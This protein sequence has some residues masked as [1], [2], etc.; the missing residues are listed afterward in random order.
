[1]AQL[2]KVFC[3]GACDGLA[4]R[5]AHLWVRRATNGLRCPLCGGP[6]EVVAEPELTPEERRQIH[7]TVDAYVERSGAVEAVNSEIAKANAA[8]TKRRKL[9]PPPPPW[10]PPVKGPASTR[11]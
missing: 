3:V 9:P 11:S 4:F 10:R 6:T 1:M 7:E 8:T 2:V 5:I